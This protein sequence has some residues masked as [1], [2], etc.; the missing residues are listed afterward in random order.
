M[1]KLEWSL[2]ILTSSF[3][4]HLNFDIRHSTRTCFV[5]RRLIHSA[6]SFVFAT[7]S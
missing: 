1:T 3:F 5:L 6:H 4:R 2:V 7:P